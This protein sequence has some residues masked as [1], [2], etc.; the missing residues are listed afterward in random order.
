MATAVQSPIKVD[1]R[2]KDRIKYASALSDL[3]QAQIVE[4]A[5]AEY[6]ERHADDFRA[7]IERARGALLNG[8]NAVIADILGID[9]GEVDRLAGGP[10]PT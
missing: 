4:F 9:K 7:G 1:K 2:T 10:L 5:V 8:P 6:V 3:R